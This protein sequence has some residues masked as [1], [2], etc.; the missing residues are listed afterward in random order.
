MT[1]IAAA[2]GTATTAAAMGTATTAAG[3]IAIAETVAT[4]EVGTTI[5]GVMAVETDGA[6]AV[7]VGGPRRKE[8]DRHDRPP[9]CRAGR[10]DL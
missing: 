7:V 3:A 4:V 5:T 1:T 8:S 2:M 6:T 10:G 9:G